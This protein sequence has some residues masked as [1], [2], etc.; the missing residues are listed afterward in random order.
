MVPTIKV[1]RQE[2]IMD[3]FDRNA[4]RLQRER[5]SQ[6]SFPFK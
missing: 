6:V 5:A 2:T 4:K 3:V 1:Q